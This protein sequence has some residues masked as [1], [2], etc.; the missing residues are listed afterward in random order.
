MKRKRPL[1]RSFLCSEFGDVFGFGKAWQ[2]Y[3]ICVSGFIFAYI[4][5][6]IRKYLQD[7]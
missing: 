5:K 6:F 7:I 2:I 3:Y 1:R 4:S